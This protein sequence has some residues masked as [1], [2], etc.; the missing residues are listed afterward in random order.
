MN[1]SNEPVRN[2]DTYCSPSCGQGCTIHQY[3]EAACVAQE[4]VDALGPAKHKYAAGW[5]K[6]ALESQG[7]Y[8]TAV[9]KLDGEVWA[10]AYKNALDYMV[11]IHC[12]PQIGGR[13]QTPALA[14]RAALR[15]LE[16]NIKNLTAYGNAV[17][18]SIQEGRP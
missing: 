18:D 14:L 17:R 13:G 9:L 6:R 2:G 7:W 11:Y 4:L 10:T 1:R 15:A 8:G 5:E 3:N 12:H 16:A